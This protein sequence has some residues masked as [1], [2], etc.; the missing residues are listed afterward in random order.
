MK[1]PCIWDK[2]TT[3]NPHPCLI[4]S[5]WDASSKNNQILNKHVSGHLLGYRQRYEIGQVTQKQGG[6]LLLGREIGVFAEYC[7][8]QQLGYRNGIWL[9]QTLYAS[10]SESRDENQGW[11]PIFHLFYLQ[12]IFYPF[13]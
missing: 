6:L 3:L 9:L 7:K 4:A 5:K 13:N 10:S 12:C 8:S 2:C 1:P 11:L